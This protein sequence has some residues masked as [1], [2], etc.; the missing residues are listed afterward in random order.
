M[1]RPGPTVEA[2]DLVP[3]GLTFAEVSLRLS[4]VYPVE[5]SPWGVR[6][7]RFDIL[8]DGTVTG[9]ISLRPAVTHLL[10]HLSGQVGFSVEPGFRGRGLA[11][12]AVR[13]LLP[14]ARA[15]GLDAL[16]FTTTP[17]NAASRRTLEKLG[18]ALVESAAVPADYVSHG[19]GEQVKLRYRLELLGKV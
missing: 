3:S 4:H 13:A 5:T 16:W 11:A 12:K 15:H 18:C 14:A 10:T 6:T 7:F 9:T 17:D 19:S 8:V 2:D 1:T